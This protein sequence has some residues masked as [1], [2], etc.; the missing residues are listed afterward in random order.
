MRELGKSTFT[1]PYDCCYMPAREESGGVWRVVLVALKNGCVNCLK[2]AHLAGVKWE[3]DEGL[4]Y[5]NEAAYYGKLEALKYLHDNNCGMD[6]ST[7]NAAVKSGSVECLKFLLDKGCSLP[8]TLL[9]TA[10]SN[11]DLNMLKYLVENSVTTDDDMDSS[12][13]IAAVKS[14]SVECVEFLS[15]KGCPLPQ[16]LLDVAAS[17][18]NLNML[19]YLVEK[20]VTTDDDWSRVQVKAIWKAVYQKGA[21]RFDMT[22]N[23]FDCAKYLLEKGCPW[24][25]E[26]IVDAIENKN[27]SILKFLHKN[28]C[29]WNVDEVVETLDEYGTPRIVQYAR[30]YMIKDRAIKAPI[31]PGMYAMDG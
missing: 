3:G 14:G 30:K 2:R 31:W 1:K 7:V 16:T 20:F 8:Q 11:G 17:N 27:V 24:N 13:L 6:S 19:K 9:N 4:P 5:A 12:T 26:E 18:A 22:E 29:P 28:K 21:S 10:A 23:Y 15:D 25:G